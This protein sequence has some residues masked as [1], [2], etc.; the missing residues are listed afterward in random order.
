MRTSFL[1]REP[2]KSTGREEFGEPFLAEILRRGTWRD[3]DLI[4]T[5]TAFT[6]QSIAEGIHRFC[7][8]ESSPSSG[9]A[10]AA[11]TIRALWPDCNTPCQ[12]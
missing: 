7:P 10:A 5:L 4:A 12:T 1:Q 11:S 3:S 8:G 6:V 2:P 9:S